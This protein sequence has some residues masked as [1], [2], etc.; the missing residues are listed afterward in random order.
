MFAILMAGITAM[1]IIGIVAAFQYA[2]TD[3]AQHETPAATA[4][5][6]ATMS[7]P[8]ATTG[9]ARPPATTT[10]SGSASRDSGAMPRSETGHNPIGDD[11]PQPKRP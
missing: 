2:A 11:F 10:G 5:T 8:P 1:F 4:S 6:P 7:A 3:T 9:S